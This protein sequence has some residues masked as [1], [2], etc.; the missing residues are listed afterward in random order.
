MLSCKKKKKISDRV[1]IGRRL[2]FWWVVG[3]DEIKKNANEKQGQ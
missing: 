2:K 1:L 3:K